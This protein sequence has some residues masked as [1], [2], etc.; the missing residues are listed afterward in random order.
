MAKDTTRELKEALTD[1]L[2]MYVVKMD[3]LDKAYVK[4]KSKINEIF[5]NHIKEISNAFGSDSKT[6]S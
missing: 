5:N 2:I 6:V 1:A 4:A 3:E